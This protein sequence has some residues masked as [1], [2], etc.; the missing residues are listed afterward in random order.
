DILLALTLATIIPPVVLFYSSRSRSDRQE[1]RP[2]I[3]VASAAILIATPLSL[4]LWNN[5]PVLGRIQFPWRY[6]GLIALMGSVL[7]AAGL[8]DIV[9]S[10]KTK[11]R[12]LALIA[13]GAIVASFAFTAAQVIRPAAFSSRAEFD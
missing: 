4:P 9:A 11:F 10:F 1:L 7:V 6:L 5:L 13:T 3:A 8:D 2:L 12:P